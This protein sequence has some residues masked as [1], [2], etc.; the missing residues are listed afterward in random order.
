MYGVDL[1]DLYRDRMTLRQA[2]V[3]IKALPAGSPLHQSLDRAREAADLDQQA[4]TV[5]D[6]LDMMRKG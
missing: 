6:A 3:R 1:G 2:W 4:Q 5:D